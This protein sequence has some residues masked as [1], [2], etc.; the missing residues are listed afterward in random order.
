MGKF[1]VTE[2]PVVVMMGQSNCGGHN[3]DGLNAIPSSYSNGSIFYKPDWTSTNNGSWGNPIATGVNNAQYTRIVGGFNDV[4]IELKLSKLLYD[5]N[6]VHHYFIK[7]SYGGVEITDTVGQDDLNPSNVG[8]YWTIAMDYTFTNAVQQLAGLGKVRIKAMTFHQGEAEGAISEAVTD[9]YYQSG[10]TIDKDNPLPY[11]FQE[12]RAYHPLLVGKPIVITKV[13]T[14][15]G[16]YPYTSNVATRQEA[17]ASDFSNVTLID[18][19]NDVVFADS[20]V[21]WNAATQ[22]LKATNVFN[23]IKN[24]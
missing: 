20:G 8:E 17:Y 10:V 3:E 7:L 5:Y 22:E 14:A 24:L 1:T 19:D 16:G 15:S 13:Y 9:N 12:L 2:I 11:L 6:G 21:H 18:M 23:I 4:G